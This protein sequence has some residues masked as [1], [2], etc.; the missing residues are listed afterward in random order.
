[1]NTY[2]VFCIGTEAFSLY[3]NSPV[4][5]FKILYN[6]YSL[7]SDLSLG[8]SIYNQLCERFD[9]NRLNEYIKLLPVSIEGDNRFCINDNDFIFI[10]PSCVVLKCRIIRKDVLYVLKSYSR[11][12]FVCD[13]KNNN[14]YWLNE[15]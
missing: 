6:L 5:L 4:S 1:M 12:L 14:Y 3:K 2:Y 7:K 8:L 11:L 9:V 15:Y 13:F 10:R